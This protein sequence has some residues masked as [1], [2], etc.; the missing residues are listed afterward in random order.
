VPE[1]EWERG[2]RGYTV[3]SEANIGMADAA[4][5]NLYYHLVGS[6]L[7]REKFVPLQTLSRSS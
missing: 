4:A 2:S 6:R 5:G 1:S 3:E 7:R